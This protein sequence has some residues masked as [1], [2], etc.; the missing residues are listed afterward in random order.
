M[1]LPSFH[2]LGVRQ[3]A[4]GL[5]ADLEAERLPKCSG[6]RSM[7]YL[8]FR[9]SATDERAG[10]M[11]GSTGSVAEK[12]NLPLLSSSGQSDC[13]IARPISGTRDLTSSHRCKSVEG[14]SQRPDAERSVGEE[15]RWTQ[16]L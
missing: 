7:V 5:V 4:R 2:L 8:I 1:Y 9:L 6:D 14:V 10:T 11:Q 13:R 12:E 16:S 3:D 15:D